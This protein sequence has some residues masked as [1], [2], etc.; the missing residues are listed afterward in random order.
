MIPKRI[1]ASF[2]VVML[3]VSM[4][5]GVAVGAWM[6]SDDDFFA[7]R[8]NFR[9]FGAVYEEVVT[10]YV[11]PV[12]P[13]HLMRVGIEAMLSELDPYTTFLDEADN[14]SIDIITEGRYG[15]VGL[16]VDRRRGEMT[17]VAPVEGAS[18]EQQGIRTGD[19]ITHV[20]EQAVAPLSMGDVRT[21]LRG[22]PGTTVEVTV[23][24]EGAS[25]PLEFT[26]TREQIELENVAYRGRVGTNADVG[27][28]KLER[29]TRGAAGEVETALRALRDG[30]DL[31]G[32]VLDLRGN[33]GG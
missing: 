10:G 6:P 16:N 13:E 4:V 20:S 23:Q 24:R 7:L 3:G 21:L 14:T 9:I 12:D 1:K 25:A 8:K 2:L 18:G 22:Q 30:G 27:Y 33:P 5:L 31:S 19:V 32:L 26:L 15:G 11:K 29:F 28:V 17:V